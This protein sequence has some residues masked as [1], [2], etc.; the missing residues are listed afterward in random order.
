M[1]YLGIDLG[2]KTLGLARGEGK[3]AFSWKTLRFYEHDFNDAIAQLNT[4]IKEYQPDTLVFGYPLNMD[5][6]IGASAQT[7]NK[8]IETFKSQQNNDKLNIVLQDER[9]T[10][11]SSQQILIKADVSRNKRKIVKDQLAAAIILQSYFD[12][13]NQQIV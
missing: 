7:V 2:S 5:G 1:K 11:Y 6:S 10:T 3:I 4:V 8:F 13:I 12:K 9:R